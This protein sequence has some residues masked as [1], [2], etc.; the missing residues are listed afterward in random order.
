MVR[1][2]WTVRKCSRAVEANCQRKQYILENYRKSQTYHTFVPSYLLHG[3]TNSFGNYVH[4]Y[5]ISSNG[6]KMKM[7]DVIFQINYLNI[8]YIFY[9]CP[10]KQTGLCTW[11]RRKHHHIES[12][13]SP[14]WSFCKNFFC[15]FLAFKLSVCICV[16]SLFSIW[17]YKFTTIEPYPP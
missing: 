2:V 4:T 16:D 9:L 5:K 1:I 15:I 13:N 3:S 11:H 17:Y 7:I 8:S 14:L 10:F 12:L 6:N